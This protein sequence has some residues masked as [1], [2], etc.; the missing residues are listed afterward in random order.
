MTD[1]SQI[2]QTKQ[3]K[4]LFVAGNLSGVGKSTVCLG[5]LKMFLS[6]GYAVKDLA[7]IKPC[8][9]CTK[10]QMVTKFCLENNIDT[11]NSPIVFYKGLTSDVIDDKYSSEELLQN[12]INTIKN[13]GKYKKIV[14]VDG[15]GYPSVGSVIGISNGTVANALK[16]PVLL[17]GEHGIG[18]AIDSTNLA[19]S[20]FA[21]EKVQVLGCI[22]NKVGKNMS[23]YEKCKYYV[24]KYFS[25]IHKFGVYGF[26]PTIEKEFVETSCKCNDSG[27]SCEIDYNKSLT[28]KELK[29][30]DKVA[31]LM[32]KYVDVNLLLNNLN[33]YYE[34][35]K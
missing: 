14:I 15:I 1:I 33:E 7:Y 2:I 12:T 17:V 20:F 27:D 3:T 24:T 23:D 34:T 5:L 9:Q 8:T 19:I 29:Y 28:M 26:L 25:Q 10:I 31:E 32:N 6:I 21:Q 11:I 18:N 22:W 35:T 4:Y 30:V 16:C 13:L